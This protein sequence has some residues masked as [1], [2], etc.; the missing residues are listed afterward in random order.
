MVPLETATASSTPSHSAKA[1]SKRS[2]IG[3]E[4]E[5]ARAQHL[6]HELL[7]APAQLRPGQ[8][9]LL[10]V[11]SGAHVCGW[12]AYSSEST[13]ASQEAS[14]MFSETPIVPHSRSP[15]EES[16]STRVIASVP[17]VSSR[18]RTL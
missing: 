1:R 15:S 12:K 8:R 17:W 9:D 5:P 16:S 2:A 10:V 6:E 14:M 11:G 4:R 3:P 7:L 18:M 13:S